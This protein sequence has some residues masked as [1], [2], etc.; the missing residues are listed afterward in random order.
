M[1]A[2]PMRSPFMSR[3]RFAL[4]TIT[5]ATLLPWHVT[6]AQQILSGQLSR[7]DGVPAAGVQLVATRLADSVVVGRALTN[8][9]GHFQFTLPATAVRL[10]AMR[11]GHYPAE[12]G[13]F[14]LTSGERRDVRLVLPD[15]PVPLR[16]VTTVAN[17]RC[18]S[19]GSA[20]TELI[21]LFSDVRQAL[22]GV[23]LVS[24]DGVPTARIV[25]MERLEDDRGTALAPAYHRMQTGASI[26]PFQA[27]SVALLRTVGYVTQERDGVVYRAPDSDVLASDAFL[28][29]NCFQFV[30][31]HEARPEWVGIEFQPVSPPRNL[32]HIRG[33]FWIDRETRELRQLDFRYVGL[34]RGLERL[35][36]G[37]HVEF[38]TLPDG[39]WI[40]SRWAIRMAKSSVQRRGARREEVVAEAILVAG[41]EVVDMTRDDETLFMGDPNLA[42]ALTAAERDVLRNTGIPHFLSSSVNLASVCGMDSLEA[43]SA[44]LVSGT[45]YGDAADRV[46][47]AT[48]IA[49]WRQYLGWSG[50][51]VGNHTWHYED[52]AMTVTTGSDGYYRLCGVPKNRDL[53]L[54]A[55]FGGRIATASPGKIPAATDHMRF[56]FTL[57]ADSTPPV[58]AE[59]TASEALDAGPLHDHLVEVGFYDRRHRARRAGF[60]AEF[61][62]PREITARGASRMSELLW[63]RQTVTVDT[64][65]GPRPRIILLGPK[66]TTCAMTVVRDGERMNV[67]LPPKDGIVIEDPVAIDELVDIRSVA[68]IE[69]YANIG[70]APAEFTAGI[71]GGSCGLV[72]VWTRPSRN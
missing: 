11:I 4:F 61:I 18:R 24:L 23:R 16:P 35:D 27:V 21:E 1:Q 13:R 65:A 3:L 10:R 56:D 2:S 49:E 40:E 68:A 30:S 46:H 43:Q 69:S 44:V 50:E 38:A 36:L 63:N 62:T 39:A 31:A 8:R 5:C 7:G 6:G 33:T 42:D 71:G 22:H 47:D 64:A 14:D 70:S 25:L 26:R 51:I 52:R 9:T 37:G 67:A 34:P 29:D 66:G 54:T 20:A 55:R 48:V 53:R 59:D 19:A 15:N 12:L 28:A 41:G 60:A 45:V 72:A 32:V 58:A 57:P 17:Q